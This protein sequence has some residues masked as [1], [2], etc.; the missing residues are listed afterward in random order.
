M[1]KSIFFFFCFVELPPHFQNRIRTDFSF[2]CVFLCLELSG[3]SSP[4]EY[5]LLP[6][7]IKCPGGSHYLQTFICKFAYSYFKIDQKL[8]V[9]SQKWTF[10]CK[11]KICSPKWMNIFKANNK[12]NVYCHLFYQKTFIFKFV[13]VPNVLSFFTLKET[14]S[15]CTQSM[16]N[17]KYNVIAIFSVV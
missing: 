17:L 6:S 14:F 5:I 7:P 10:I 8:Q 12:G 3:K 4:W 15:P 9:S 16:N 13:S 11:C 2:F 1:T